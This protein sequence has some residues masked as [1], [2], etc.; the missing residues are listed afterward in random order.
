MCLSGGKTALLRFF[1]ISSLVWLYRKTAAGQPHLSRGHRGPGQPHLSRGHSGPAPP[2]RAPCGPVRPATRDLGLAST[3][4]VHLTSRLCPTARARTRDSPACSCG[5]SETRTCSVPTV[6]RTREYQT[7][8]AR[9]RPRGGAPRPGRAADVG[10]G[11]GQRGAGSWGLEPERPNA[12]HTPGRSALGGRAVRAVAELSTRNGQCPPPLI[13]PRARRL[14]YRLNTRCVLTI[15]C[16]SGK[17][18]R[19]NMLSFFFLNRRDLKVS[20]VGLGVSYFG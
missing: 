10:P 13:K 17:L 18:T 11:A 14:S 3:C 20:N 16:F 7:P 19:V 2:A 5:S 9:G 15:V 8:L 12:D 4:H 1:W 6:T